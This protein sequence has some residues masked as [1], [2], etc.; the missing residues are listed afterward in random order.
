MQNIDAP[1]EKNTAI[2]TVE[3]KLDPSKIEAL[4]TRFETFLAQKIRNFIVDLNNCDYV[5]S[6]TLAFLVEIRRRCVNDELGFSIV[7]V[8]GRVREILRT[9]KLDSYLLD[10]Q[11]I[12]E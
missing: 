4:R 8:S 7:N 10:G 6:S 2:M 5:N 1:T 12:E 11:E 9:T 3:S